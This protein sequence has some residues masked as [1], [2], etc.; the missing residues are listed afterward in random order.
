MCSSRNKN[1]VDQTVNLDNPCIHS[2]ALIIMQISHKQPRV[3]A[4]FINKYKIY[5]WNSR[6]IVTTA[7][8][9]AQFINEWTS[10]GT[11]DFARFE[12]EM[13]LA[14]MSWLIEA[15]WWI[16]ASVKHINIGSNNGLSPVRRQAIICTNAAILSIRL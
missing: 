11:K 13:G 7:T 16:Y 6:N 8:L 9:C 5:L 12:F 2:L 1:P 14:V 4:K 3:V 10:Y 15:E